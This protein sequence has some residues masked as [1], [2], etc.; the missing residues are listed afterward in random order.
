MLLPA[1][2]SPNESPAHRLHE[3][4]QTIDPGLA[5][6]KEDNDDRLAANYLSHRGLIGGNVFSLPEQPMSIS[7]RTVF[8]LNSTLL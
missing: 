8:C 3:Q 2:A 1:R 5:D 6:G 4:L 7:S